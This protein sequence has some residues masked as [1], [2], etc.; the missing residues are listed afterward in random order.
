MGVRSLF[1]ILN[2]R[3]LPRLVRFYQDAL[4]ATVEYRFASGAEDD[5]VSLRLGSEA[6]G[7]G[8]VPDAPTSGDR[9][10]LWFYVDDVDAVHAEWARHGGT[11]VQP[12]SDMPWGER[13]AQ[14]RDLDGNLVNLGAQPSTR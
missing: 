7:I 1:P 3:D 6:L 4:G 10:A 8:R 13:V 14:V 9:V 5:Y 2:S 12:P 11:T